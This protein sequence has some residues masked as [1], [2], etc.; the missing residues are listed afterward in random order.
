MCVQKKQIFIEKSKLKGYSPSLMFSCS[1]QQ[2]TPF[3]YKARAELRRRPRGGGA[4]LFFAAFCQ[5]FF[6]LFIYHINHFLNTF[7]K[8]CTICSLLIAL[9]SLLCVSSL[10]FYAISSA[11]FF[12][13]M[14]FCSLDPFV[15]SSF[16]HSHY[17]SI[18]GKDRKQFKLVIQ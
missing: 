5:S 17:H 3:E 8:C 6:I 4:S 14:V 2:P 16:L 18:Y 13:I 9:I 7:I 11:L 15:C 12:P 1:S 10:S